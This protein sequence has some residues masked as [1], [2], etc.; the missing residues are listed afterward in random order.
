MPASAPSTS[1]S[2]RL[3]EALNAPGQPDIIRTVRAEGYALRAD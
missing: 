2:A 3:R 1:P